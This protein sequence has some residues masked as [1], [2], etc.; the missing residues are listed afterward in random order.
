[1]KTI[2]RNQLWAFLLSSAICPA[3]Y[4]S[5]I[6]E[7]LPLTDRIIMVHFD[8]GKVIHHK[9]GENRNSDVLKS[10]P[11]DV[12]RAG[13]ATCYNVTSPDDTN[14][15]EARNPSDV[16]RKSKGTDFTMSSIWTPDWQSKSWAQEHWIYLFL[17]SGM[18]HG[19]NYTLDTGTLATGKNSFS[20]VFNESELRSEAI[21]VNQV[22]YLPDA[23]KKYGYVYHW[24]GDKGGLNLS[25]YAG[26]GF[27]LEDCQSGATVFQGT[28]A[29]R[30]TAT[31]R[32]TYQ[33]N[34]T[35]NDNFL[36]AEVYECDFSSFTTP[37][38]YRLVVDG[39]GSSFPFEI[40]TD[41]YRAPF[42][43]TAR[44]LYHNR[45]GIELTAE[46]TEF[47]RPAP[48][49]PETTAGFKG[50]LR[51]T[52]VRACD[53][54]TDGGDAESIRKLVEASDKGTID[55]WGWYQDAG[56][57][58]GYPSHL[59]IPALL[60][61]AYEMAPE[62]FI[63]SE[64]D[65]PGKNN[66]IP[67]I[68]DEARWLIEYL[69]RTRHAIMD[70]GY[71]TGGVSSRVCGDY[72][73]EDMNSSNVTNGSW[74]DKRT[75]YVFGEDPMSTYMYCGL[76]AEYAYLLKLSG[77]SCP[78]G[79]D[80]K[81]E[82]EEAFEWASANTRQGDENSQYAAIS[83]K[84]SRAYAAANLYKLSPDQKYHD[85]FL[86]Y[87]RSIQA[88]TVLSEDA[89]LS[90][91]SYLLQ[92]PVR[93][94]SNVRAILKKAV[95]KT[96]DTN[97][98]D[99]AKK[100]GCRWGGNIYMPMLVGQST[101]P[102]VIDALADYRINGDAESLSDAMTTVD[103]FMGTNPLNMIWFTAEKS[104][105]TNRD[106]RYVTGIFHMDSWYNT[107]KEEREVPG[108][109]PYGPWRQDKILDPGK[110]QNQGWWSN[111][112]AMLSTYP[113]IQNNPTPIDNSATAWPGH[114]RWFS[115]RYSPLSCENTIHQN[116]VHWAIATGL[117]CED[118]TDNPFD[119]SRLD[120]ADP[121][122][123]IVLIPADKQKKEISLGVITIRGGK[124]YLT[125][126]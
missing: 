67:D 91:Y 99:A 42:R 126:H 98:S 117:L 3:T 106:R 59:R 113:A 15:A 53:T 107:A 23:R 49:N 92:N 13:T 87:S 60:M 79:I 124:K 72:W 4:A 81:K 65:I 123:G 75:W 58:D 102:L 32:E 119:F 78:T 36:G 70:A 82:A 105:L 6:V 61:L 50:K 26:T 125:L 22:G 100:R 28:T 54:Q 7:V 10:S 1:M 43:T 104:E 35:P 62:K 45:S 44:G 52:T 56:D 2:L 109:S 27:R 30:A 112:W 116:T 19:K 111:E 120:D 57:W 74:G 66:G 41:I 94:D 64:L 73:G 114:E 25:E 96:A 39:I 38:R 69:H 97:V 108:F 90:V 103:Y 85:I 14:Y 84:D 8:D 18:Q 20:F 37:G 95:A 40:G 5:D 29:F 80:W 68:L 31:N 46:Y 63:D 21:H 121:T 48:H 55:T 16:G 115:Q 101:T 89:R 86:S 47:T 71:G 76:A 77:K 83:L 33:K 118:I 34:E 17:P 12:S 24:M 122:D 88:T 110:G 93:Q 51:Y 11:L 9:L